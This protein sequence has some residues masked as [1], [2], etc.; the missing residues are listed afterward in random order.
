VKSIGLTQRVEVVADYGERRDA[1]DQNWA[2]LVARAGFL[3]VP[4]S[5]PLAEGDVGRSL[6]VLHLGGIILT[7]GNDVARLADAR[8]PAPERD[9]FEWALLAAALDRRVPVLGVCRGMQV[10]N[11]CQGGELSPIEGHAGT[12]H[13]LEWEGRPREV[14]SYHDYAV[15]EEGL[16]AG[17]QVTARCED[18]SIEAVRHESGA[19]YGVMWHPERE[20]PFREEDLRFLR[21][22]FGGETPA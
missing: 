19:L 5:N 15:R 1:L 11:L 10:I 13:R 7:G 3:P 9:R 22:F 14:G 12:R 20:D 2:R 17:L 4:L 21:A 18:Q 6:D 8:N 16:G